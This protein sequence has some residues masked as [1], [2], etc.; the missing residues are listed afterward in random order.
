MK[1]E[2]V[3]LPDLPEVL[4]SQRIL[5]K[6]A[7]NK[8]V[9]ETPQDFTFITEDEIFRSIKPDGKPRIIKVEHLELNVDHTTCSVRLTVSQLFQLALREKLWIFET[10]DMF[11]SPAGITFLAKKVKA[12]G[13]KSIA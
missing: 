4:V 8:T 11:V 6:L 10:S 7:E 1:V 13:D 12:E 9:F 5:C 2:H 3:E